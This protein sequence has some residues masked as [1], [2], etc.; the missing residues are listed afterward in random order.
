MFSLNLVV[1]VSFAFLAWKVAE[2]LQRSLFSFWMAHETR[3]FSDGGLLVQS[4]FWIFWQRDAETWLIVLI[5]YCTINRS[6]WECTF[7]QKLLRLPKRRLLKLT[8]TTFLYREIE[9]L[10]FYQFLLTLAV[11]EDSEWLSSVS[12]PMSM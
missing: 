10:T 7:S 4:S 6:Y 2:L 12:E 3:H 8:S 5:F 11:W 1:R 9:K